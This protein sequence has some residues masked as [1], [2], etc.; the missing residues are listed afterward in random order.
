MFE[1][2]AIIMLHK[3]SKKMVLQNTTQFMRF[4]QEIKLFITPFM[5]EKDIFLKNSFR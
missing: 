1:K 2:F 4:D 5:R 3:M